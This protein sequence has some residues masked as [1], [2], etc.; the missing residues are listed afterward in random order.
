M[1]FIKE[2]IGAVLTFLLISVASLLIIEL[3]FTTAELFNSI[4]IC[5]VVFVALIIILIP[6][7]LFLL[8]IIAN[9][10]N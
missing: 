3:L 7:L 10:L 9:K 5:I 4:I 6:L 2:F 1:D 8:E